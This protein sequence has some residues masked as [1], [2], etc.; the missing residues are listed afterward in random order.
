MVRVYKDWF[1]D[2]DPYQYILGHVKER[3]RDGKTFQEFINPTYHP[4]IAA[5]VAHVL[6]AESRQGIADGEAATLQEALAAYKATAG[7]L[8]QEIKTMQGSLPKGGENA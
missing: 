3:T 8:M 5:A 2:A 4:T 6:E 7:E 1:L